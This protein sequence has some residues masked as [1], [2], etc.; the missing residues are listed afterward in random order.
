MAMNL[1]NAGDGDGLFQIQASVETPS[2]AVDAAPE[3]S[4]CWARKFSTSSGTVVSR[5]VFPAT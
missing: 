5:A 3:S 4:S 1:Y 2:T